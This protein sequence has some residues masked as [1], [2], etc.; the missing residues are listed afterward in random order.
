MTKNK[1]KGRKLYP[2]A[3]AHD[4]LVKEPDGS[5]IIDFFPFARYTSVVGV[6]TTLLAFTAL[7]LPRT[8]LL[9]ESTRPSSDS[10]FI[11]SRDRPQH[12][13]L[14]ALTL[15]P[16]STLGCICLGVFILQGWWGGWVRNWFVDYSLRGTH[17]EKKLDRV[18]IEKQRGPALRGAWAATFVV[19]LLL[20]A[21]LILFGAP[22][23]SHFLQT[24]L[25]A[26]LL[27][28]L[29]IFTPA[30]SIGTPSL[31][32]DGPSI[33]NRMTWV[34][35]FAELSIRN[36][37]ERA[38]VYPAIGTAFGCWL[39][40]IPIALDWDR[41]WQAWPLTPAFGAILGYILAS[42]YALTASGTTY[43]ADEHVRSL[44]AT[45]T[46]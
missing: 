13:F 23:A 35:L 16:S 33:V 25:L 38:I 8:A 44:R 11:T 26:L 45:K 43:L 18:V 3:P 39:G 37:V 34:R 28:L 12:P 14:E 20:H 1:S 17:D 24:Y 31:S 15:S 10:A 4:T 29:I 21:I 40:V 7:F 19:S 22:V 5:E 2:T 46:D 41:P 6:H 27:S 32:D 36:P 42:M 30:Y 9:F